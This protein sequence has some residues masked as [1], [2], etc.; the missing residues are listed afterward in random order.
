LP[1]ESEVLGAHQDQMGEAAEHGRE[2]K[3]A[4]LAVTTTELAT[5]GAI[6]SWL[7]GA[8]QADAGVFKNDAAN[9][10]DRSIES[11]ELP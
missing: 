5:A 6:L 7:C 8:T 1:E 11:T 2:T 3:A 4:Q 9:R 10:K